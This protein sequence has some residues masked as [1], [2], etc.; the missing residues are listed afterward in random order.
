[1]RCSCRE[2]GEYMV[3][4]NAGLGACICPVCGFRC[5]D[6]LGTDSVISKEM[7]KRMK[8]DEIL[9]RAFIT[10]REDTDE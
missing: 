10:E 4:E 6:C 1:M 3:H 8:D 9:Q 7:F 2:C 5:T